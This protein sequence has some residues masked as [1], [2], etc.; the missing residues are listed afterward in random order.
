L[1]G[2]R[3]LVGEAKADNDYSKQYEFALRSPR[4][5]EL[6]KKGEFTPKTYGIYYPKA[7]LEKALQ[8]LK[9]L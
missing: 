2:Q 9:L 6:H 3:F 4:R 1:V 8:E 7:D 5:M